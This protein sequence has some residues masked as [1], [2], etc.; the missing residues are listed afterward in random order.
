MLSLTETLYGLSLASTA[1]NTSRNGP[2]D[3]LCHK[4]PEEDGNTKHI[5][6]EAVKA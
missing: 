2:F 6:R 3:N 5:T 1:L 4:V